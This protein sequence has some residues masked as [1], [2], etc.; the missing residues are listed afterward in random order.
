MSDV[1]RL[2]DVWFGWHVH[3]GTRIARSWTPSPTP[4]REIEE[5]RLKLGG[6]G[7]PEEI[8]DLYRW[9]DGDYSRLFPFGTFAPIESV[10]NTMSGGYE[11]WD[12]FL[13]E[14][15]EGEVP[16][17]F[18]LLISPEYP[19]IH[20]DRTGLTPGRMWA[21]DIGDFFPMANSFTEYL[22]LCIYMAEQGQVAREESGGY[23]V[24]P[25]HDSRWGP[26]SR[27]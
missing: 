5:A 27:T 13:E 3:F 16:N 24:F 12:L 7:W 14:E 26:A 2:M 10:A 6:P 20:I 8:L 11:E 21:M 9:S 18:P 17:P 22:E 4:D 23:L 15:P 25:Y 1:A 19:C